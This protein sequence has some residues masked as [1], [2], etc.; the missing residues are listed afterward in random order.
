MSVSRLTSW[1]MRSG[2]L[3]PGPS[4]NF[5]E[6]ATPVTKTA[7]RAKLNSRRLRVLHLAGGRGVFVGLGRP[8]VATLGRGSIGALAGGNVIDPGSTGVEWHQLEVAVQLHAG[9]QVL[10]PDVDQL[11]LR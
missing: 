9:R 6:A 7:R 11:V 10:D 8:V 5:Q 2:R 3:R 4:K 1:M